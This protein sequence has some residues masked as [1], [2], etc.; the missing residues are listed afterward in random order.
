ME[1]TTHETLETEVNTQYK[2]VKKNNTGI[3]AVAYLLFFV[4]LLTDVKDDAFVKF[5]VKQGFVLFLSAIITSTIS[6][7]PLHFIGVLLQFGLVILVIVG[8][9]NALHGKKEQLPFIGQ[10]ADSF[11][12]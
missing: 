12:F 9:V 4:P 8:I 7:S 6:I 1:N 3:A 11:T 2:P 5:H 10:F